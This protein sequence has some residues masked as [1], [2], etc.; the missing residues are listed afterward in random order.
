[1]SFVAVAIGGSALVGAG[2]SLYASGKAAKAQ[3]NAAG[4][5]NDIE[6]KQLAQQQTQYDQ[7]RAD[8]APWRA[9]GVTALGDLAKMTSGD[10][11]AV[12]AQLK[13]DPGYSFRQ[14]QGQRGYEASAAARGGVLSGGAQKALARY[15]QDYASGEFGQRFSRLSQL[16]GLG[17]TATGQGINAGAQ[18]TAGNAATNANMANNALSIG[19]ANASQYAAGAQAIGGAASNIGQYFALK[20]LMPTTGKTGG[21]TLPADFYKGTPVTGFTGNSDYT[22]G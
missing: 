20:D 22:F 11:A 5:A 13:S 17:Q 6:L 9:A 21:F 8:L 15:N 3:K 7:D 18:F 16:A 1:M 19:N 14:E 12:M 10:P 2:A 4:Q